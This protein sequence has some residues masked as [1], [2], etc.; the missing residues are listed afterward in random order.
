VLSAWAATIEIYD[1]LYT[2]ID[3][4][5]REIEKGNENANAKEIH[6]ESRPSE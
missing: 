6:T 2:A 4:I 3:L 5:N 1:E